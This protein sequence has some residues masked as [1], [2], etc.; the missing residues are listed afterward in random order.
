MI[1]DGMGWEMAR[2]TAIS[3]GASQYTRGKGSGLS[4]QKLA[5]Y[6]FATTYGTTIFDATSGRFST[7]NSA[8]D[9]NS[10]TCKSETNTAGIDCTVTGAAPVRSGFEFKPL[11]FNAG[12]RADGTGGATDPSLGNLVGYDVN[13]GGANPWTPLDPGKSSEPSYLTYSYPDSANTASTLYTGVKSFNNA[14]AVDVF[15]KVETETILQTAS[16]LG[17]STGVVT[18]VPISHAT[19]G[20]A[21]SSVNRRSKYDNDF[22][23]LDNILQEAIRPGQG[24]SPTV[25]LGGGHPLDHD[26]AFNDPSSPRYRAPGTCTYTYIKASTYKE[27]TGKTSLTDAEACK[28]AASANNSNRYGY[29]FVERQ[30]NA[31]TQLLRTAAAINPNRGER[32]LGL[33]GARGQGGNIPVSTTNGDYSS[34]GLASFARS[35]SL[36]A[37]PYEEG[38]LPV[39][40]FDRPLQP[41]ETDASFIRREQNENPTLSQMTQAALEVL[42]KDK[43]GF[44]LMVEGGDID[45]AAHDNN[46]DTLIGTVRDFD[47]SVQ[48]VINWINKNG[49][50]RKNVLIVTA[51]HDH[52]LTLYPNYRDL[53][54]SKGA[55]AM[56]Y[57]N[58]LLA[59]EVGHSW[60]PSA[61]NK[62]G[63]GSHTNRMVPVY[64]QGRAFDLSPYIGQGYKAYGFDVPGV[65]N[66]IDQVHIYE[67]M[68]T[69]LSEPLR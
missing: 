54:F 30:P 19:P 58:N 2:A 14:I 37:T 59:S 7:G 33:F 64:Y 20:A 10:P 41:G 35:S 56:T 68:L 55:Q 43:E 18:S 24:F 26:N 52:Y 11:P 15:E 53:L 65:P 67:A 27:L 34:T 48:T 42:G 49:G 6:T 69:A 28:A 45:W 29:R 62:Y 21:V 50:W 3:N 17:K 9:P 8:L 5:G 39:N 4:M 63:W 60:G 1:G 40:D 66:A 51:D 31:G 57:G 61:V 36:Y 46:L 23:N 13:R 47:K 12:T 25:L 16:R 22:P 32:L 38:R 44:W